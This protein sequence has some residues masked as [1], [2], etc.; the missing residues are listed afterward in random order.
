MSSAGGGEE[1]NS[2]RKSNVK[3]SC[4]LDNSSHEIMGFRIHCSKLNLLNEIIHN[5]NIIGR[6]NSNASN[7]G[8]TA[9]KSCFDYAIKYSHVRVQ[10]Q[11]KHRFVHPFQIKT[12]RDEEGSSRSSL[13]QPSFTRPQTCHS[14]INKPPISILT[15]QAMTGE[16]L[17]TKA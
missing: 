17:A 11:Y 16:N 1:K 10:R 12:T 9:I 5:I 15:L 14:I 4:C 6:H 8:H 13:L 2:V 3:V 7:F